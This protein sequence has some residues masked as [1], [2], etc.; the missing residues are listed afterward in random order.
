M[1]LTQWGKHLRVET[2][3]DAGHCPQCGAATVF[4]FRLRCDRC[5]QTR[6]CCR[7]CAE[8]GL[9]AQIHQARMAAMRA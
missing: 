4:V 3:H 2:R 9:M 8:P 6:D 7:F 1:H 5:G